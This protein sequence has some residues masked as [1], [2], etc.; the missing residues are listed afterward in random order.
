MEAEMHDNFWSLSQ[1]LTGAAPA[2]RRLAETVLGGI[3]SGRQDL[4]RRI[5]TAWAERPVDADPQKWIA[6]NL[7]SSPEAK[8]ICQDITLSWFFGQI[9]RD[10]APQATPAA[11][12]EA[13]ASL[14]FSG[15]FWTLAKAHAPGISGGYFGHW[16]Y[17]GEA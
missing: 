1:A 7:W 15:S 14:W 16:S 5:L 12:Q 4:V 17:P 11:S 13:L 6:A 8:R 3:S 10:G 2:D 9:F